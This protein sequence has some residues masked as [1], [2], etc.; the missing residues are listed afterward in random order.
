MKPPEWLFF[1]CLP[2]LFLQLIPRARWQKA[3]RAALRRRQ[4]ALAAG[5]RRR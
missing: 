2:Y 5:R 4:K 1:Y 3:L